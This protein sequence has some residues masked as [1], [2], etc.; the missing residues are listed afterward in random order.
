MILS[1]IKLSTAVMIL[2][3]GLILGLS[4]TTPMALSLLHYQ[5]LELPFFAWLLLSFLLG[6]FITVVLT[7]WRLFGLQRKHRQRGKAD[8]PQT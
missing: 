3:F 2:V 8:H 6:L 5:T 1:L 4:N 7:S